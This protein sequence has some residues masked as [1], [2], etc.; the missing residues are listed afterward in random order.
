MGGQLVRLNLTFYFFKTFQLGLFFNLFPIPCGS[1]AI[2]LVKF[3]LEEY[4]IEI[5]DF[6]LKELS[7]LADRYLLRFSSEIF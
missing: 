3:K 1:Q 6:S 2:S 5:A 7:L 4:L